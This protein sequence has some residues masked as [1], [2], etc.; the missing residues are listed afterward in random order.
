MKIP[1]EGQCHE[2]FC[3]SFYIYN[4]RVISNFFSRKFME[5]LASQG[6]NDTGGKF[7]TS[8]NDTDGKFAAG[9]NYT[10]GKE[11]GRL[12]KVGKVSLDRGWTQWTVDI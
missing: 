5:I 8:V 4:I 2:I 11:R 12:R 9:V 6:V 10:G 1:L 7:A 3:F